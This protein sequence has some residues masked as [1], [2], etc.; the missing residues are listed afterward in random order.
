MAIDWSGYQIPGYLAA[1]QTREASRDLG[2]A[3]G[4]LLDKFMSRKDIE[5]R[6]LGQALRGEGRSY[7]KDNVDK[8]VYGSYDEWLKSGDA[9]RYLQAAEAGAQFQNVG[10][11]YQMKTPEGEWVSIGQE[12]EEGVFDPYAG[13]KDLTQFEHGMREKMMGEWSGG[14]YDYL[15][16]KS[17][18]GALFSKEKFRPKAG[19][20]EEA[21]KQA[22]LDRFEQKGGGIDW[23]QLSAPNK[24][25]LL[26]KLLNKPEEDKDVSGPVVKD[27]T[28]TKK[29]ST[30]TIT[31]TEDYSDIENFEELYNEHATTS[32]SRAMSKEDFANYY[33]KFNQ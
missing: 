23:S 21:A 5:T 29:D 16:S 6:N 7:Y 33:R 27:S 2:T 12:T 11:D 4:G 25:S 13:A 20:Y 30:Q 9:G 8:D 24:R 3:V 19:M 28:P 17:P 26:N 10:G 1:Q 15:P 32:G 18:L 31:T 22:L 14:V